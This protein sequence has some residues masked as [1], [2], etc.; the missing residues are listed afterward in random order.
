[1]I[2]APGM[3]VQMR[4]RRRN[5]RVPVNMP[6][7]KVRALVQRLDWPIVSV[8]LCLV[9]PWTGVCHGLQAGPIRAAPR[10]EMI[11]GAWLPEA[12]SR[13]NARGRDASGDGDRLGARAAVG[14]RPAEEPDGTNA[15]T[16]HPAQ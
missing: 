1:M 15:D 8:A 14:E 3:V 6:S 4:R 13:A 7:R 16:L 9:R 12:A 5:S 2:A 10:L 11:A